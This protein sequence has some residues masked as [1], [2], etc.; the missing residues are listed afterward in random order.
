M[1]ICLS[2]GVAVQKPGPPLLPLCL[3]PLQAT[4]ELVH[5]QITPVPGP[6]AVPGTLQKHS[7]HSQ[8]SM[9]TH[10]QATA[11]CHPLSSPAP[12]T[13]MSPSPRLLPGTHPSV[14][15]ALKQPILKVVT[16]LSLGKLSSFL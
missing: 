13:S 6:S 4:E 2:S 3:S 5:T 8:R 16:D 11:A 12:S 9:P 14:D 7:E 15:V 1:A 10:Q